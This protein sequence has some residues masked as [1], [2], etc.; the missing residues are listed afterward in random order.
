VP[1]NYADMA[2]A[3]PDLFA[4]REAAQSPS[5]GKPRTISYRRIS[6]RRLSGVFAV[7][8]SASRRARPGRETPV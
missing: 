4:G 8:L 3:Y 1:F 6:N 5:S 2:A 7:A